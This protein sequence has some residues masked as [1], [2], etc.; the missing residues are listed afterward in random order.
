LGTHA[1][2]AACAAPTSESEQQLAARLGE[3]V[4]EQ[5]LV[6]GNRLFGTARTLS[7]A[8]QA[9]QERDIAVLARVRDNINTEGPREDGALRRYIER[10]EESG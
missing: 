3:Q 7:E 4:P 1:P 10:C 5:S 6:M 9:W 8:T 2:L